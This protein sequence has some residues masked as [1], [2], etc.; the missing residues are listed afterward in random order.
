M[1]AYFL[2]HVKVTYLDTAAISA[3]RSWKSV[4][5]GMGGW[6][7]RDPVGHIVILCSHS[8]PTPGAALPQIQ[9]TTTYLTITF[10]D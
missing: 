5:G 4:K 7:H 10:N 2:P 6:S 9:V 1:T 3:V 8:P